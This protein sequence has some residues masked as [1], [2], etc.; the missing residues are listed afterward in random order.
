ML[1]LPACSLNGKGTQGNPGDAHTE[2][3][4][5]WRR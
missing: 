4:E 5:K 2:E 1:Y 3:R